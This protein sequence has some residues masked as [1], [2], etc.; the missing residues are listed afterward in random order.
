MDLPVGTAFVIP[1]RELEW[2]FS[3]SGGPGGQHANRNATRA[4]LS[5]D[6]SASEAVSDATRDRLARR[7]GS[8]ARRGVV[9]VAAAESRSQWRNRQIA[10]RRL[11]ELLVDAL[12]PERCGSKLDL[13]GQLPA[14][15][16]RTSADEEPP[17]DCAARRRSNR[18]PTMAYSSAHE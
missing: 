18:C 17:S 11:A 3:T 14:P 5:W 16:S 10:R 4:E 8:K 2:S 7:L 15:A 13:L 12:R 9:S 1:E 6:L